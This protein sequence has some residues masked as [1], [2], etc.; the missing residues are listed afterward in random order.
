MIAMFRRLLTRLTPAP[1]VIGMAHVPEP[2][3]EPVTDPLHPD[4]RPTGEMV[5]PLFFE[6]ATPTPPTWDALSFTQAW[7]TRGPAE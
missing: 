4:W 6:R 1:R 7:S 3:P 5:A 2:E